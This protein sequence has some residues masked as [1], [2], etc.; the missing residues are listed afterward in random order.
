MIFG[1]GDLGGWVL[2][3][4]SREPGVSTII[5]ADARKQYGLIKTHGAAAGS[6]H[7]GYNKN[8]VFEECDVYDVDRTAELLHKYNPDL[9][10]S[11]MGLLSP[12]VP[13]Y[14]PKDLYKKH[15]K[16]SGGLLIPMHLTLI[17]KLMQAV[18]KSGTNAP[19]VNNSWPDIANAMLWRNG[20]YPLVGAGNFDIRVAQI[21]R[22]ISIQ[23]NIPIPQ[24]Q[25]YLVAEHALGMQGARIG[26]PYFIKIMIE[27]KDVTQ[28]FDTVSLLSDNII[29]GFTATQATH[30]IRPTIASCAVRIILAILNDTNEVTHAPGPN[31]MIGGYPIRVGAK[32]VQVVLPGGITM[33]QA[34]KINTESI[35]FEGVQEIR[36][37]GT[38]VMTEEGFQI[39]KELLNIEC[40]EIK[41]S[42]TDNW[43][44]E[45]LSAYRVLA[46]K[47]HVPTA[48]N[49]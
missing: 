44:K 21:R 12:Q 13:A 27:D 30:V 33:E 32:G 17:R 2:E 8:I 47:Y 36:E 26:I 7:M 40:R 34:V 20:M 42:D 35:K 24:I 48:Y 3:F 16:I 37:D 9:I 18:Q 31:G 22:R 5:T 46:E 19:V 45:I 39:G 43:A 23:R 41:V 38:L 1:L 25:V 10:Y 14:L 6:G 15:H 29:S 11:S 49:Y 28:E 4:L